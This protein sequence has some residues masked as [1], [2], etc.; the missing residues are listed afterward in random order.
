[1]AR[2]CPIQAITSSSL[3]LTAPI[4]SHYN[5]RSRRLDPRVA[6][7]WLALAGAADHR[8]TIE[9]L[10]ALLQS[11]TPKPLVWGDDDP[12]STID[13]AE[14]YARESHIRWRTIPSG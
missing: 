12:F 8:Y 10:P 4:L 11:K 1:M 5:K 7:S 13:N 6:R 3:P 9:M 14:R 2:Y